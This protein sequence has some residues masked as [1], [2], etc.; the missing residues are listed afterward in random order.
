M[1]NH[2]CI[3]GNAQKEI[4]ALAFASNLQ[5]VGARRENSLRVKTW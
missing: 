4:L 3:K 1:F 5:L 2:S